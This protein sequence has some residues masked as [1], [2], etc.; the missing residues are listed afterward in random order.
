MNVDSLAVFASGDG[1]GVMVAVAIGVAVSVAVAV[2]R[3]REKKRA[4][5]MW[6][7]IEPVLQRGPA[8]V[9]ELAGALGVSGLM[10]EGKLMMALQ[11]LTLERKILVIDAPSG[12]PLLERKNH[13]KYQLPPQA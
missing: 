7:K 10:A 13:I 2:N 8:N 9:R 5:A 4:Q 3:G 1:S 11:S 6:Q 12:T